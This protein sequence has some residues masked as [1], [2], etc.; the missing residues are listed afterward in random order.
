MC[1]K[2]TSVSRSYTESEV[3]SLDAGLRMDGLF[4]LDLWDVVME[5]LRSSNSTKPPTNPA[6]GNCSRNNKSNPKQ[7]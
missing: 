2:H 6:A 1:K 3:I 7:R 4:A 5:A